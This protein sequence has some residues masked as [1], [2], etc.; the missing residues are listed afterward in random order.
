MEL[1]S[2]KGRLSEDQKEMKIRFLHL[3]HVLH[4]VRT[5]KRFMEIVEEK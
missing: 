3:G 2:G 4:E 1:K 5:W